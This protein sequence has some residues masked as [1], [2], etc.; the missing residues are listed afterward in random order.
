VLVSEAATA[1]PSSLM[2]AGRTTRTALNRADQVDCHN[3]FPWEQKC[4]HS[5]KKYG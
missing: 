3:L 4:T 5:A 2:A 1:A